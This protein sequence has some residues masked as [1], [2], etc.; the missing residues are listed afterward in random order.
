VESDRSA[1]PAFRLARFSGPLPEPGGRLTPHP[2]LHETK[3]Y[4][5]AVAIIHSSHGVGIA[6]PR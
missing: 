4:P 6:A 3:G 5:F 1:V 2:A